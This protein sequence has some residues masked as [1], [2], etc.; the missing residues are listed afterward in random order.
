MCGGT[1]LPSI[2]QLLGS[3]PAMYILV[4]IGIRVRH[5]FLHYIWIDCEFPQQPQISG[6]GG[7]G[8]VK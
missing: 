1:Q 8:T 2:V 6:L 4:Y 7:S 3:H 5:T